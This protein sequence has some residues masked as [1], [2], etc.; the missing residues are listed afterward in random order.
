MHLHKALISLSGL[1]ALVCRAAPVARNGDLTWREIRDFGIDLEERVVST[2]E[3]Y[4]GGYKPLP[5]HHLFKT[6]TNTYT[7]KELNKAARNALAHAK[8]DTHSHY[9][10]TKNPNKP[11]VYPNR[12]STGF[13]AGD[14]NDPSGKHKSKVVLHDPIKNKNSDFSKSPP[15]NPNPVGPD[16]V[17][18]WKQPGEKR[19]S[20]H[21]SFHDTSKARANPEAQ[22]P[23]SLA[24][25]YHP[26]KT[27]ARHKK[28]EAA[29]TRPPKPASY[30][31][32]PK[33]PSKSSQKQ[34]KFSKHVAK[35]AQK[36]GGKHARRPSKTQ[37]KAQKAGKK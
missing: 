28:I 4:T 29:L 10:P 6:E 3:A 13:P 20:S 1:L 9:I 37:R 14:H 31:P 22:H 16:R 33:P 36:F 17:I 12:D 5:N 21:I 25:E 2:P 15:N 8:L 24:K 35:Q 30:T 27:Q 23:A 19:F 11:K 26:S 18:A 34:A 32:R 7:G